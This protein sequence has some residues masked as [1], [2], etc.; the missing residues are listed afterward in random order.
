MRIPTSSTHAARIPHRAPRLG[1][2]PHTG[3]PALWF[4][5]RTPANSQVPGTVRFVGKT[6]FAE[7]SWLGLEVPPARPCGQIDRERDRHTHRQR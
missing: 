2:A 5:P 4:E 3:R 6:T 7:G 1:R